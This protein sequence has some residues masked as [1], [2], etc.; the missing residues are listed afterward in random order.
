VSS[1]KLSPAGDLERGRTSTTSSAPAP[2]F[3]KRRKKRANE[4][5]QLLLRKGCILPEQLREALRI[6]EERGGQ[7]GAILV[8]MGACT[9]RAIADALIEQVQLAHEAGRPS[10]I[11]IKARENPSIVGLH[12]PCMPRLTL[13]LL[14]VTDFIALTGGAAVGFF[15]YHLTTPGP[16]PYPYNWLPV[17]LLCIAAFAMTHLYSAAPPSP[18]D[19]IRR[20]TLSTSLVYAGLTI[21]VLLQRGAFAP[22]VHLTQLAALA[23]TIFLLPVGRALL[24][25]LFDKKPWWGHPVVVLGAGKV[26]R[27]LVRTLKGRPQLGLKPVVILDDDTTKHGTLRATWA[28]DDI[29]VESVRHVE[30]NPKGGDIETPSIRELETPSVKEVWGKFSEV[31]GVPVVGTLELAPV[32]A[33]RLKI[34]SAVIAMPDMESHELLHLIERVGGTFLNVLVI[35]DLFNFAYLGAPTR[36]L[37]GV[38]G[39]ELRRQLL[40]PGPRF[41]KRIIDVVLTIL[42]GIFIFPILVLLAILIRLDSSGPAFYRQ[43]RLGQDGMR[44]SALKFRTMYGDGE[45][46]L[47]DLL[48]KDPKLKKEYDEFHKLARDPRVTRLGRILRK[49]SLDELPQIWNVLRGDMSLVGP[50]PYL[51]REIPEMNQQEGIILRVKPGIT[52]MWQVTDRNATGFSERLKM[53]VEYVRNWSPWL[54]IYI[55]ARTLSVVVAGT[56]S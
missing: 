50:R 26:G 4:L 41:A 6:Q 24:R 7:V 54:D 43:K 30:I 25:H 44:F 49:Y 34:K 51:E 12:V 19:E 47:K 17:T 36:N 29:K 2:A 16:R 22:Y 23:V 38:L 20:M 55:L 56:G 35:P 31:E 11:S 13:A 46:R 48:E 45:Q 42:G 8:S 39:I 21:V 18:P 5:G 37:G 10:N 27:S 14:V 28:D 15:S 33:Q 53:D 1:S 3:Y 40:L 32:L 52:G 9:R